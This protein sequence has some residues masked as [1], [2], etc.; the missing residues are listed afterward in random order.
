[1]VCTRVQ[2]GED[3]QLR[4]KRMTAIGIMTVSGIAVAQSAVPTLTLFKQQ[5]DFLLSITQQFDAHVNTML[6][7][8]G[9][10]VALASALS[11]GGSLV[12]TRRQVKEAT[13]DL[14]E[15][16]R[17][18]VSQEVV[19]RVGARVEHLERLVDREAAVP[20]ST[21]GYYLS[22]EEAPPREYELLRDRGFLKRRFYSG[23]VEE[24]ASNDV[25][26]L[27]IV[28]S[29]GTAEDARE[30]FMRLSR[31]VGARSVV[32]IYGKGLPWLSEL[33]ADGVLYDIANFPLRLV[34]V[35]ANAAFVARS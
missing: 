35:C 33:A 10:A 14:D 3:M 30:A 15:K 32:V 17:K 19:S 2:R 5:L 9:I 13:Q 31:V 34:A 18:E 27:D 12:F 4:L 24:A 6:T 26:V 16:V 21:L 20:A 11:F 29:S 1:M 22:G 25:I 8:I 28:N 7:I 23:S